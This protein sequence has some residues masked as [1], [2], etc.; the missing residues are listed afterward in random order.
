MRT[1]EHTNVVV[2][3]SLEERDYLV[4]FFLY[5][6]DTINLDQATVDYFREFAMALTPRVPR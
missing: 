4:N 2:E 1:S 6:M 5:E 3:M